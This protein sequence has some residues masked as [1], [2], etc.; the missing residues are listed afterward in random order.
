MFLYENRRIAILYVGLYL[1]NNNLYFTIQN[2]KFKIKLF[3]KHIV[4][5]ILP[6]KTKFICMYLLFILKSLSLL[7]L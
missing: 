7:I 6:N 1:K 4:I 2:L 3:S 5:Y